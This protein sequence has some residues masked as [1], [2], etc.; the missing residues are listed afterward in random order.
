MHSFPSPPL[1]TPRL[2]ASL[3][4]LAFGGAAVP[5]Q[6]FVAIPPQ[7]AP[8][9]RIDFARH[10][11][12]TSEDAR[13]ERS[14]L[15]ASLSELE[16]LAGSVAQSARNLERALELSDDVQIRFNR[17]YSYWYLRYAVNTEDRAA[18]AES[19][20]IDTTFGAKTA[21]LRSEVAA[22]DSDRLT[23]LLA[24]RPALARYA[25]AIE[26]L[27]REAP[28]ILAP[29]EEALLS[30][31]EPLADGWQ[32]E[33]YEKLRDRETQPGNAV[34]ADT[35]RTA[36]E[37]RRSAVAA[38]RELYAFAL[39]RLAA[40]RDQLAHRRGFPDAPSA[41]YSRS[42]W[43][44]DEVDRR[45]EQ[46]A[47]H[48]DL[49]QRF[50]RARAGHLAEVTGRAE[51]GP[52]DLK[53]P[54]PGAPA[55][56]FTIHE[57]TAAIE[58]ATA[59]LGAAYARE[60][61][62]LLD[63]GNG[64]LDVVPGE[65]RHRGGFSKGFIGTDSVFFSAGFQGT[66]NDLRVLTH[67]AAHAVH[68]QLMSRHH[69][70]PVY[71]EGPSYLFEAFAI[72]NEL[73]LP[74]Y[75][76][77]AAEAPELQQYYLERFLAGKGLEMF[78]VAPEVALEHAVYDGVAEGT[79]LGPDGLDALT[80]GIYTRFTHW[81]PLYPELR[82]RWADVVLMYEDPFYDVN[83]VYGSLVALAFYGR[84]REDPAAFVPGYLALLEN[85]F[86]APPAELLER[87]LGIDLNDPQLVER[88]VHLLEDKV[89][90]LEQSYAVAAR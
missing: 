16:G 42:H 21:F 13:R 73:L 11:Y 29:A 14:E 88:A 86:D 58:A 76:Y 36:F 65:H 30:S 19:T 32:W 87:F 25:F 2:W 84:Y 45:I 5:G 39:L 56:R 81:Q 90:R 35:A 33:L 72:F 23:E 47:R 46:V 74:D 37:A 67:E 9:Y 50:E 66:Y 51:I 28:H 17:L 59:P 22:I 52:W 78:V 69:V 31:T 75:L 4:L 3:A 53:S 20:E 85:G 41:A 62:A 24:E 60:I 40:A 71:A 57:A 82:S 26:R 54:P 55:P 61:A 68:R 10:W 70:L 64:R 38:D 48:A 8:S 12:S 63:P 7:E 43:T 27:R 15:N 83:Y 79:L 80:Q 34:A 89:A 6:E 44:R 1:R 49:Y 18:L 77:G